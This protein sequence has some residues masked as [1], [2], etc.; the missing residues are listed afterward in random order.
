[1]R[2]LYIGDKNLSSW[3]LRPW[4]ALREAEIPFEEVV[5]RLDQPDTKA[6]LC[7][8]SPSG[9]V[10]A[11]KE[12]NLVLWDSFAIVEFAA[13]LAPALWPADRAERALAR[14]VS[15]E[16]HGGFAA[17]R[18]HCPMDIHNVRGRDAAACRAAP[19][20]AADVA[21]IQE[22]WRMCLE[23]SGGPFLFGGFTIADAMYA[24]VVTRFRTYGVPLEPGL[25]AYADAIW[26]LP[27]MVEWVAGAAAEV[28]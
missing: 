26:A 13:E 6:H 8:V 16:M 7:A 27:A 24:P 19:G 10:P 17:L 5:I 21:R 9:R 15:A 14:S 1:M 11:L 18:T 12:R 2:T 28:R 20:V 25:Q 3:S 22:V 4:L 23:R